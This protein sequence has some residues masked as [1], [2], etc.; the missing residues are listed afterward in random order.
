MRQVVQLLDEIK[1]SNKRL[2][3]KVVKQMKREDLP[4]R[5]QELFSAQ[6]TEESWAETEQTMRLFQTELAT[7]TRLQQIETVHFDHESDTLTLT[8][9]DLLLLPPSMLNQEGI[10]RQVG[11]G[12]Q[13]SPEPALAQ[14]RQGP[15]RL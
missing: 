15:R 1:D 8:F 4:L 13:E 6:N 12:Q 5:H 11:R 3:T 7:L 2:Y 14:G 9:E 10:E